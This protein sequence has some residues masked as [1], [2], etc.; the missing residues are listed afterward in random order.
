MP[1]LRSVIIGTVD[2]NS[3]M[4]MPSCLY[5]HQTDGHNPI[6][7]FVACISFLYVKNKC[8]GNARKNFT[9]FHVTQAI[10][11]LCK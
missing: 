6:V 5:L 2:M 11:I 4:Y 7:L 3:N 10:L 8:E 1:I 9:A